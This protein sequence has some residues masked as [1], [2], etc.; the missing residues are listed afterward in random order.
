MTKCLTISRELY[1]FVQSRG[2]DNGFAILLNRAY[3]IILVL[4]S[5]HQAQLHPYG[6]S[7]CNGKPGDR[8]RWKISLISFLHF[9]L[10]VWT[11]IAV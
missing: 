8:E 2:I 5:P 4:R 7:Y 9:N 11:T 1:S 3:C 10:K 6:H